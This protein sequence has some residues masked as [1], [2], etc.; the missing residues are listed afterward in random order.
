M[1]A[2]L[3]HENYIFIFLVEKLLLLNSS[4][5]KAP[6]GPA[7]G[8]ETGCDRHCLDRETDLVPAWRDCGEQTGW[9]LKKAITGPK[10]T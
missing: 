3:W 6:T 7:L 4:I 10:I 8:L 5:I 2:I 1:V 9:Q